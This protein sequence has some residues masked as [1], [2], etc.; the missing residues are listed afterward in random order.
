MM[1]IDRTGPKTLAEL[2]SALNGRPYRVHGMGGM[3]A[4][5]FDQFA[6]FVRRL[7][8]T[9]EAIDCY[10]PT[11]DDAMQ[12][13]LRRDPG[14]GGFVLIEPDP[15]RTL[16]PHRLEG[17]PHYQELLLP[18]WVKSTPGEESGQL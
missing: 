10:H 6:Y 5:A 15:T 2:C 1:T 14:A 13:V 11:A 18:E 12:V 4:I 17:Q 3:E 8:G 7:N 9:A 16:L